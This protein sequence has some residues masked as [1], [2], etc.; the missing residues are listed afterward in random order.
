MFKRYRPFFKAG[1]IGFFAY[2]FNVFSWLIVSCFQI[3]WVIFLWMA[4]YKNSPDG[5]NSIINGFTYKEMIVYVVFIN[6]FSFVTFGGDTLWMINEDI[7]KGTI[8]MA[9][10]KPISYRTKFIFQTLGNLFVA[11]LLF[12]LPLFAVGYLTFYLIHF[13][14]I[15]S[16]WVFLGRLGLFLVAQVIACILFDTINYICGI[17]CFYTSSGWGINQTKEVVINFLSGTLLPLAFF[18]S[19]IST[20]IN[21]L[22]FAG[23]A[24]NPIL[25]IIG[26]ASMLESIH[27]VGLSLTWAIVLNLFAKL[28]FDHASKKITVQGG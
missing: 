28:L 4:V 25:I 14:E 5:V 16:I 13:I 9:F 23:M 3:L 2:K 21:Y 6:M 15:S 7:K 11:C 19:Q 1:A 20:I 22:P 8:D 12:G 27:Y 17:L 18:P 24:Y 26:K 10:T